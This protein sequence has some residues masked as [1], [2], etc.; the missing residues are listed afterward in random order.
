[1]KK[2][3]FIL[4]VILISVGE[5]LK[6]VWR[7]IKGFIKWVFSKTTVDEKVVEVVE[8]V[9]DRVKAVKKEV[10]DVKKALGDAVDESQDIV[11]A[12]KGKKRRG[13]PKKS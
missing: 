6:W 11:E 1:M 4:I 10:K 12:A 3:K 8:E 7:K 13:R 9:S 5:A 2:L